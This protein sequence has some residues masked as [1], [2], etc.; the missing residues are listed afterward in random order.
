MT[1]SNASSPATLTLARPDDWHL[2]VRD[3]EMLA[4]VLPHTARQFG[5][6]IIMPNLKPP[7]TTTAQAHAYRER[8]L[9]AVPAGVT[10]EPL[11]TLYL[12]DNTPPDEI[13]RARESG[14][15]HGVKLYP[16]GATTNSDH[17]V[18]DLAKCAKTLE[19]MQEAGMPLLVHGEVTDASIDLF[20]REK[21]FIDRVMTPLRRDF[22]GLKVVFEHITTKD[23]A[24]YV[25]DAD[26]APGLIG[27]T[28][29]AH[30]LLYN[31]NAIFVGGIRP[32]YYCLPVLK[33]ET[34]RVA[35]VEAATSGNPR[36]FLG[37]DSAPHARNAKEAACGCA[38]CYTALHAL[39]LYAEA[40]DNAGALDKL[41]GFASFYGADFY[42]LPRAAETVT[43]RR[44]PWELPLEILAGDTPVVPLRAGEAIGWKLA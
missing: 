5:R 41:E 19:A 10:F 33:R 14:F 38:G 6:A 30:H 18:T 29:T 44:E 8:I 26:A 40:F 39:E 22:P 7:V 35:L 24:D 34:H 23:A 25:R 2:H 36:F 27:A 11:M 43:L 4:A 17:G 16:A 21:V 42:G 31:R 28:I 32:H 9:A 20:D 12:T 3:G 37:T 15:V 13:R 1:A